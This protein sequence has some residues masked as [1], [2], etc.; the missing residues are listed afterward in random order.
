MRESLSNYVRLGLGDAVTRDDS[1]ALRRSTQNANTAPMIWVI[2]KSAQTAMSYELRSGN[3]SH[4]SYH[5]R[6]T[7]IACQLLRKTQI[8]TYA[9]TK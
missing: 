8:P 7:L 6:M 9:M 5:V 3:K 1:V 4:T 2:S